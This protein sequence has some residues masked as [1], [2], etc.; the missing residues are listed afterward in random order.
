MY[1]LNK[2]KLVDS[3]NVGNLSRY[4]NASLQPNCAAQSQYSR[5]T[6]TPAE[7][8]STDRRWR[9]WDPYMRL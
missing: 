6:L 7:Q 4:I 2:D 8:L 1:E 9:T 3:A 5:L